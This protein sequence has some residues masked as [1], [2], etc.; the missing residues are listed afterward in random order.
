VESS[1]SS[2]RPSCCC[3]M[4]ARQHTSAYVSIRQHTS[5]YVSIRQHTSA[6]VSIRS[7]R[8]SCCCA[9]LA[10]QHTSAYVSIRSACVQS[11]VQHASAYVSIRQHTLRIPA[12]PSVP[13]L[14]P[15]STRIRQHTSAYVSTLC[16]YL[17]RHPCWS[18]LLPVLPYVSIRQHT[19]AY[20]SIPAAPSVLVLVAASPPNPDYTPPRR[21]CH[22]SLSLKASYTSSLRP[23][24]LVA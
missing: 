19:S 4:L 6:Y 11:C 20:V 23:H 2:C 14:D 18:S 16:A 3:A 10:R 15:A 12:A 13:V 22:R 9:L 8:P 7:C 21:S 24:T 17:L 5:A 1:L